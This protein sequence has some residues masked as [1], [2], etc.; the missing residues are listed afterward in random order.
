LQGW[1]VNG[2]GSGSRTVDF[3]ISCA[4]P[5]GSRHAAMSK[6]E[7]KQNFGE[8]LV[9]SQWELSKAETKSNKW[10]SEGGKYH[11]GN[12]QGPRRH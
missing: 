3:S 4:E 5:L 10:S 7:T 2:T 8:R 6:T 1:V 9:C 11:H 12:E